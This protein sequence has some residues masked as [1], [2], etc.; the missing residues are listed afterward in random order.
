MKKIFA[1]ALA[2]VMV[3]SMASAFATLQCDPKWD[4]AGTTYTYDCGTAQIFVDEYV[5]A[6]TACGYELVAN[7]CAAAI[8]SERVYYVVRLVVP[9]NINEDWYTNAIAN[10]LKLS[11][12]NLARNIDLS[13]KLDKLYFALPSWNTVKGGGTFYLKAFNKTGNDTTAFTTADDTIWTDTFG[14]GVVWY[15]WVTRSCAKVC[16]QISSESNGQ[17]IQAYGWTVEYNAANKTLL[18]TRDTTAVAIFLKNDKVNYIEAQKAGGT[19]IV[20][21][22]Y[23]GGDMTTLTGYEKGT[24]NVPGVWGSDCD[25]LAK[26]VLEIFKTFNLG[27]DVP[28]TEKGIKK[29]FGWEDTVKDCTDYK[30]GGTAIVDPSCKV[31]IPKTGDA[32]VVA[33]AVMALVAAAGAMGLKK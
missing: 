6:N 27:F 23:R 7:G 13:N 25:D 24:Q 33:Y 31:E 21:N 18:F 17:K 4:W 2:L 29:N 32:S 16:A 26:A 9:E 5:R 19:T 11:Y 14:E 15:D 10:G 1:I 28:V 30:A 12:T 3:L 8:E 20:V 22:G